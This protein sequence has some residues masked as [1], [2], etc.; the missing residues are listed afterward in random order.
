MTTATVDPDRNPQFRPI[1]AVWVHGELQYEVYEVVP[2]TAFV[3]STD[4]SVRPTRWVF[5]EASA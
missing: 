5:A 3:F 2:T 1:L 4:E